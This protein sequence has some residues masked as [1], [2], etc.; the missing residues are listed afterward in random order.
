MINSSERSDILVFNYYLCHVSFLLT[1]YICSAKV[2]K[3]SDIS[4][5]FENFISRTLGVLTRN[6]AAELR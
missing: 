2:G 5:C 3:I 4:M 6:Y 1:C